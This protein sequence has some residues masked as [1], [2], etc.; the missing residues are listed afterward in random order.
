MAESFIKSW[1][2]GC[3]EQGYVGNSALEYVPKFLASHAV[4]RARQADHA[5]K[6]MRLLAAE[7]WTIDLQFSEIDRGD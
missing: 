1:D 3:D 4:V 6:N 5:A 2:S 7:N